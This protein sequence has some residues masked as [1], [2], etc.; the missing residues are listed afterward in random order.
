[1]TGEEEEEEKPQQQQQH[2]IGKELNL[3][4]SELIVWIRSN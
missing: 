2:Y 4:G 1:V 3:M